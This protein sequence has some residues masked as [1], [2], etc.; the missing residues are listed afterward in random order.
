[1]LRTSH[2]DLLLLKPTAGT[3]EAAATLGP[4]SSCCC[5]RK[6]PKPPATSLV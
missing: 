4:S 1:M 6:Q 2:P 3:A 5:V